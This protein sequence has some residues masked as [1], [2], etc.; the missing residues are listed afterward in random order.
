MCVQGIQVFGGAGFM[1]STLVARHYRD[2]KILEVGEGTSEIQRLVIARG[3]RGGR[4]TEFLLSFAL[5]I[6]GADGIVALAKN[7]MREGSHVLDVNVDYAGR[8]NASDMSEIVS[9]V[10]RQVDAPLM[11]DSTQTETIEAGQRP[12][13]RAFHMGRASTRSNNAWTSRIKPSASHCSSGL[14]FSHL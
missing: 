4:N 2:A 11:L 6:D 13:P 7:Q 12:N 10:V 3:G 9:R 1:D 5:R 8:D 14:P